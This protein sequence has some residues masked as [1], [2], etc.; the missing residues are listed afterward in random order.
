MSLIVGLGL[1]RPLIVQGGER[2]RELLAPPLATVNFTF[3]YREPMA[4][5][6]WIRAIQDFDYCEKPQRKDLCE[7]NGW[8][9]QT[10]DL[11]TELSPSFRMAYSAGGMALTILISDYSGASKLFD[12]AVQRFPTD[13]VILYKAAYHVLYEE[14]DKA[15][16]AYLMERAARNGAP[17]WVF[18]L[19][20][21]LYTESGQKEVAIRLIQSLEEDGYDERLINRMKEK[22]GASP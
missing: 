1:S 2:K 12:K 13:W 16:A 11:V 14:K 3:G 15:K 10:L 7:G 6:L 17:D 21:R 19:A 18:S 20:N 9:S 22:V 8:L 4:D 5:I